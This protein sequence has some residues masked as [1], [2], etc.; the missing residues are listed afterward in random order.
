VSDPF[1]WGSDQ[2]GVARISDLVFLRDAGGA[3]TSRL[4]MAHSVT[5]PDPPFARGDRV[6]E[7]NRSAIRAAGWPVGVTGPAVSIHPPTLPA[8]TLG[9]E[10][11]QALSVPGA[12][13]Q[14]PVTWSIT[15]GAP[16][17]GIVLGETTGFLSGVPLAMGSFAFTVRA[18][19]GMREATRAY[20]LTVGGD[21]LSVVLAEN[22]TAVVDSPY[23][24]AL[25]MPNATGPV[26]WTL[27]SGSLPPGIMLDAG[28]GALAGV[29]A[30]TGAY[31]FSVRGL[32]PERVGFGALSIAVTTDGLEVDASSLMNGVVGMAYA[33]TLRLL[34]ES[35][36]V[37]WYVTSGEL[38][39]GLSLTR[40]TGE[41]AGVPED[42]GDF[43]FD[44]IALRGFRWGRATITMSVVKP[45][46]AV[47]DAVDALLGGA[48]LSPEMVRYLDYRGNRN[49]HLDVGDVRAFLRSSQEQAR[50]RRNNQ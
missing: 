6:L 16:P 19:D 20:T 49:G 44:V 38:P 25:Q 42:G 23:T 4:V 30:D 39:P 45:D 15:A 10:Y 33:D 27:L 9:V 7:L 31:S 2:F 22:D 47:E 24:N 41:V 48:S 1:A 14:G 3:T 43:T 11:M 46:V 32:T 29:P 18:V 12:G 17:S 35:G 13:A 36:T 8:A 50:I 26:T 34:N 40:E 21:V 5:A 28:T 37:R